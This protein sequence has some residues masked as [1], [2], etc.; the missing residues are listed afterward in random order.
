MNG[1]K[2]KP[3]I[4]ITSSA[5]D[6]KRMPARRAER[7]SQRVAARVSRRNEEVGTPE[8]GCVDWYVYP[9]EARRRAGLRTM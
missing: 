8:Y 2:T 5:L 9:E 6:E 1:M 4:E 3:S 7:G